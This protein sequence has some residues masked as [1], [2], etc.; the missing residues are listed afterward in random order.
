MLNVCCKRKKANVYYVGA[1]LFFDFKKCFL[2]YDGKLKMCWSDEKKI[3]LT[4]F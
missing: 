4:F 2:C 3:P 1:Q